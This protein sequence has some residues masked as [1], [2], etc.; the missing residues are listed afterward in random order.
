MTWSATS[1]GKLTFLGTATV[2][3]SAQVKVYAKLRDQAAAGTFKLDDLRIDSFTKKEY[4]SNQNTVSSAV[5]TVNGVTVSVDDT[6]LSITRV[7]GLGNS[8][9]AVGSKA[10]TVYGLN[11]AVTQGNEVN[12]SNPE[13]TIA[14]N[15]TGS[16][17]SGTGVYNNVFATLY[18][19]GTAVSTKTVNA[20]SVKFDGLSQK[21]GKTAVN[22]TVKVDLS[23]AFASGT[24][25]FDLTGLD[26][27][28]T[29]TSK[30]LYPSGVNAPNS[31]EFTVADAKGTLSDSDNNPKASLLLAGDK[32]QKVLAFRLK[33]ENDKVTLRDLVFTGTNLD[34]LSNFRLLTP[35][36]KYVA[37]TN[38]DSGKVEFK[39]VTLEDSVA[40]DRTETYYLVA[41]VNTNVDSTF[42]VT[43]D[44]AQTF[45]KGSNGAV[46]AV[47]VSSVNVASKTHKVAENKA[48][49]AKSSN[50][51][52]LLINSALRFSVTASGKD[53]VSLSGANLTLD[54]Y[55][56][57]GTG[58][59]KIYKDSVSAGN[60]VGTYNNSGN[61]VAVGSQ[62]FTVSLD[63]NNKF[64]VDAGNTATYVVAVEG[65]TEG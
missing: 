53:Q 46:K 10:V 63:Q 47:D 36:N 17:S 54:M 3:S 20:S 16:L 26:A 11:L 52:K 2:N 1:T 32:D 58:V 57:S 44:K 7:D 38:S 59:V 64:T 61:G 48:V 21:V 15:N 43:L 34:K 31:A 9:I 27:V 41:D 65:V 13:F 29:L 19:N 62:T 56:V 18:V 42:Q 14:S 39:N 45:I 30:Q 4:V 12:I 33:A 40:M 24:L 51:S 37:S 6:A 23:D 8:K 25:S 35:T 55:G 60:L 49:I 22:L 50:S 28:D 5:G